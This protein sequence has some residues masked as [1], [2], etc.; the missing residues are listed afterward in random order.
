MIGLVRTIILKNSSK[1]PTKLLKW[2]YFWKLILQ[3]IVFLMTVSI[4]YNKEKEFNSEII[5]IAR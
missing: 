3:F 2:K 5:S 1:P 4:N